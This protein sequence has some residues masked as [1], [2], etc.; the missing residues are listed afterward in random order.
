[1]PLATQNNSTTGAVRRRHPNTFVD[2]DSLPDVYAMKCVG[3]CMEPEI[4]DGAALVFD[5]L[6]PVRTGDLVIVWSQ[7]GRLAPGDVQ[8]IVKRLVMGAGPHIAF[9]YTPHPE[10]TI[11]PLI[12]VQQ[13]NP[14]QRMTIPCERI[15]AVHRCLGPV[16]RAADGSAR[17]PKDLI[18]AA[19]GGE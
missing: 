7:A 4:A 8:A 16:R 18:E 9:P 3:D 15:A 5:K 17:L 6:S 2:I 14:P 19:R 10:S 1:M 12:M 13:N 11:E